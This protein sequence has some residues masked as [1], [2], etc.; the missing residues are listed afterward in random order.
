MIFFSGG[1][2]DPVLRHPFAPG[3]IIITIF[4]CVQHEGREKLGLIIMLNLD[5][6]DLIQSKLSFDPGLNHGMLQQ[7]GG[8]DNLCAELFKLLC[9]QRRPMHG[10][11]LFDFLS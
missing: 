3:E 7:R 2:R 6:P 9:Y 10:N 5:L 4:Y 8:L 11:L 1:L